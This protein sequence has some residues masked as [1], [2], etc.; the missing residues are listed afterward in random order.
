MSSR[1]GLP[2]RSP[3]R[4]RRVWFVPGAVL[5]GLVPLVVLE[6]GLAALGLGEPSGH[7]DPYAGFSGVYR[8]VFV[9][10]GGSGHHVTSPAVTAWFEPQRFPVPKPPDEIRIFAVG[11]STVQG[12]PYGVPTAFSTWLELLLQAMDPARRYRVVNVGGISYASYR[13][14]PIVDELL[15][16]EPDLLVLYTGHNEFLEDRTY[17]DLKQ[18]GL[19]ARARGLVSRLRTYNV[20]EARLVRPASP[21]RSAGA[22]A[23]SP[24]VDEILNS[25]VG[26][27]AYHRDPAWHRDVVAHYR[28]NLRAMVERAQAAG[29]PLFLMNPAANASNAR[30]FKSEHRRGVSVAD[31]RRF[32][33]RLEVA[34]DAL[35]SDPRL[36]LRELEVALA[37]DAEMAEA[38][39]LTG[40]ALALLGEVDA[41]VAAHR[42]ALER[43]VCPLRILDTMRATVAEV[44]RETGTPLLD[45]RSVFE[46]AAGTPLF[47]EA[48]FVDHVHPTIEGHQLLAAELVELAVRE[49]LVLRPADWVPGKRAA[50][51]R[52]H[53]AG[54]EDAYFFNGRLALAQ[55]LAWAH[56]YDEAE[57]QLRDVVRQHPRAA[58]AYLQIGQLLARRGRLAGAGAA[59]RESLAIDRTH[60]H[61]LLSLA[62]YEADTESYP[63]A[64]LALETYL[65]HSPPR[66]RE[67]E[68]RFGL[69][70]LDLLQ[71]NR[72]AAGRG[73]GALEISEANLRAAARRASGMGWFG[74]H[75]SRI[76]ELEALQDVAGVGQ[77]AADQ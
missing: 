13:L 75:E 43:D 57:A 2:P 28:F 47:G 55:V 73:Y 32:A 20:L 17:E 72:E 18:P 34:R 48:L 42:R 37:I 6:L 44:A 66:L 14:L 70:V 1:S 21:R 62:L 39:Y 69:A 58:P 30:P 53:L 23:L 3:G 31:A 24:D 27:D 35:P 74:Q 5:L 4:A 22:P 25:V 77:A 49:R 46:R 52:A 38:H 51:Y 7:L 67:I 41:A 26:L 76:A 10:D 8:R 63:A 54:L 65:E 29:V 12:R 40:K 33:R 68:A 19:V 36:A 61:D 15:D 11:G 64:R 9:P 71:G 59:W 16:Y 45:A 60:L 50:V 56:R